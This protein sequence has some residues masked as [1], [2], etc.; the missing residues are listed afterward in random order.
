MYVGKVAL[1]GAY[2]GLPLWS[3]SRPGTGGET[4]GW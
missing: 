1:P 2:Q 4:A 3:V